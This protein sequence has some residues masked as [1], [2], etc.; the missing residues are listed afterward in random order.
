MKREVQA[1]LWPTRRGQAEGKQGR[2]EGGWSEKVY[3]LSLVGP[4]IVSA[5]A[6]CL[7]LGHCRDDQ[8]PTPCLSG[9]ARARL[10]RVRAGG[11]V[12]GV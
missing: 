9:R 11:Q 6:P 10:G 12:C 1:V 8:G 2:W 3:L 7:I 5:A 4:F